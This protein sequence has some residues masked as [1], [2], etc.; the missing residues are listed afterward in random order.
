[1]APLVESL[2]K[3]G[4]ID[5]ESLFGAPYDFRYGLAASGHPSAVGSKFLKDLKILIETTSSNN[6]G[7]PVILISH[8]LGGLFV[9]EL[10]NRNPKTWQ[11]KFVKHFIA[12]SSP[13]GGAVDEMLT[14]ASGNTLGVPL[15]NPLLVRDQQ[16]RSESNLW[17][18][19]NPTVF[20]SDKPLVVGPN[21]SYTAG[22][23]VGF[24]RDIG[25]P[26]GVKPYEDRIVPLVRAMFSA[27]PEVPVTCIVGT[28]VKTMETL[29]YG[30]ELGFD[31]RPEV[32]YGDGDGTVNIESLLAL[33]TLW[34]VEKNPSLK[35]I[36]LNGMSHTSVLNEKTALEKIME[37]ISY[38]NCQ[39]MYFLNV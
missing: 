37:E 30:D 8:S 27:P 35:V 25:F 39:S 13:W 11:Q 12:I 14:L 24:L 31:G 32:V 2:H 10:L 34:K 26:E 29:F 18:L 7:K 36:R 19:P 20:G 33:E 9:L 15:V 17:L 3:I 22:E 28:G 16:R 6:G 38:V 21:R 4:Y 1:M 5:D 23:V